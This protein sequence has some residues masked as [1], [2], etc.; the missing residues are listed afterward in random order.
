MIDAIFFLG[1]CFRCS[2]VVLFVLSCCWMFK[3]FPLVLVLMVNAGAMGVFDA[4]DNLC[5]TLFVTCAFLLS[6]GNVFG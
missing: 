4:S 3:L 6:L 5:L 1:R 2:F